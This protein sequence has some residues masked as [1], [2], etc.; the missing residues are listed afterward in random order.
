MKLTDYRKAFIEFIDKIRKVTMIGMMDLIDVDIH[1]VLQYAR[2]CCV[3]P[4]VLDIKIIASQ[5]YRRDYVFNINV[6][7]VRVDGRAAHYLWKNGNL[8][9]LTAYT[10]QNFLMLQTIYN[11]LPDVIGVVCDYLYTYSME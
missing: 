7:P 9:T 6:I 1:D 11:D 2:R 3:S 10:R 8:E 5:I 4:F